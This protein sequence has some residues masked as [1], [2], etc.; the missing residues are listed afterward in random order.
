MKLWILHEFEVKGAHD[1]KVMQFLPEGGD[2]MLGWAVSFLIIALVAAVLG[3]GGIGAASAGIAKFL[4]FLTTGVVLAFAVS[5]R[6]AVSVRRTRPEK[7]WQ[8]FVFEFEPRNFCI[9]LCHILC[10]KFPWA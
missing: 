8:T 1:T 7:G 5:R 10:S 9:S 3:F 4:F 2:T 6:R